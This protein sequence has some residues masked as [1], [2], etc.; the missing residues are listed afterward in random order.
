MATEFQL[1]IDCQDP[2][3]LVRF[4]CEAL[5]YVPE[6]PPPGFADWH[7]FLRDLGVAEEELTDDDL[8]DSLIDPDG[9]G[10]RIWFQKVPEGKQVKNRVHLDLE[11]GGGRR[12]P[13]AE[14]RSRIQAEARR[15]VAA[16]ARQLS[17]LDRD[18]LDHYGITLADPE[19]NE[20]CL[21]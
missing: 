21:H 1:T 14:R 2:G 15:L 5:G 3:R 16:G 19:G 6:P 4:W 20:F 9:R 18:G 17:E 7:E 8:C 12:T 10:P 13:M 11:I